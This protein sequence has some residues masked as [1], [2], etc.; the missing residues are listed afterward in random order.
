MFDHV[1]RVQGWTTMA[2]HMY[3]TTFKSVLIIG[4]CDMQLK[5]TKSQSCMWYL[6]IEHMK[7]QCMTLS[8]FM[9]KD[10]CQILPKPIGMW[11]TQSLEVEMEMTC[12]FYMEQMLEQHR[13][14]IVVC[15]V[16]ASNSLVY[17]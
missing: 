17:E 1:K 14:Y 13:I 12:D 8:N 3:D 5:D 16:H 7:L 4:V 10:L 11:C 15:F 2:C 9:S 6:M